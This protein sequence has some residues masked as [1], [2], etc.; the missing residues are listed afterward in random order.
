MKVDVNNEIHV[1]DSSWT[2]QTR[3]PIK[4]FMV[5]NGVTNWKYDT[6]PSLPQT[7]GGF[8][9]IPND[10]LAAFQ[11]KNCNV[12]RDGKVTGKDVDF[13]TD[14]FYNKIN[15]QIPDELNAYDLYR[16]IPDEE[17]NWLTDDHQPG[18][19]LAKT[20]PWLKWRKDAYKILF[21]TAN[22]T[23][24]LNQN[25]TKTALNVE[26]KVWEDCNMTMNQNWLFQE[27][28]SQWIYTVLKTS[29]YIRMMHYSG[30]TDGVLPTYGTKLWIDDLNWPKNGTY[31]KWMTDGQVSGF[32]QKYEGL[33]FVTVKGVGHM[34]PQW[35][36]KPMQEIINK[37]MHQEDMFQN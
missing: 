36:R 11:S 6:E 13:C 1:N 26:D 24:W 37:W 29:G 5:G 31:N 3:I 27:E 8:D 35:A 10:W 14:I 21:S 17:Q 23:A 16:T 28:A 30:D 4:G 9:M 22:M 7:L 19:C 33:D 18:L 20:H 34:A 15:K 25:D 2:N 32:Y 12:D